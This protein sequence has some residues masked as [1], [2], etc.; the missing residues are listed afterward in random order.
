MIENSTERSGMDFIN[1]FSHSGKPVKDLGR[2]RRLLAAVGD[3]Q[4][5]LRFVHIAGTNG[6]GSAAEM[7]NRVFISAGLKTGC[8]TSPFIVHYNDRIRINSCDIADSELSRLAQRLS[9]VLESFPEKDDLS[10]FEIT[11]TIAFLYFA[12]QKCDIVVLE[13]GLGG[14]LDC[15]NIISSPLL[16][17]IM[18]IDFDHTAILGN[19]IAEIA[20][21][22]AGIIKPGVPCV[23][24]AYNPQ[25]AVDVVTNTA[26]QLHSRVTIP[27]TDRLIVKS[28]GVSG[29]EFEYKGKSYTLSMGGSHQITNAVSVIEG[30]ELLREQ[31]GLTDK[32]I[33]LGIS[34]AVLPAR[35][36]ILCEKPLTILDGAHN[37]DGIGALARV[38]SG[39][40]L[41]CRAIIGMCADKNIDSAVKKL[42]PFVDEFYTTDGFSER[43]VSK[44]EL[45]QKINSLGGKAQTCE[46]P[47][48]QQI[49]ALQTAYPQ[50][51]TLVCGSLYLAA[52]IKTYIKG[53]V[54]NGNEI[55]IETGTY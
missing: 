11:Q 43:A 33:A 4:K 21:Q 19:T 38:L 9:N 23:L 39:C 7:F 54:K 27:D 46:L 49:K 51:I 8:F 17:V 10:Q 22:K 2:I 37:P 35:V 55:R 12:K 40:S 31:L 15:T 32:D 24:S 5:N 3:P 16:S 20:A 47:L 52:Q 36:E 30:C 18:T 45:A 41:R 44:T 29:S 34:E 13:T 48:L 26:L 50:D 28:C 14:L 42:I 53:E 1:S 6:K 25:E